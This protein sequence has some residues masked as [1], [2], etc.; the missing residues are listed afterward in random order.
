MSYK[1]RPIFFTDSELREVTFAIHNF[2]RKGQKRRE[3]H[4]QGRA[5]EKVDT[6]VRLREK[7]RRERM[8]RLQKQGE[9]NAKTDVRESG[10]H[11]PRRA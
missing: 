2:T 6:N 8:F 7:D 10:N 3:I 5:A 4:A 1:L 11:E 9:T